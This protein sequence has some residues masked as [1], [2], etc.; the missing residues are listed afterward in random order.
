MSV[1]ASEPVLQ[2]DSDTILGVDRDAFVDV[3]NDDERLT[4]G[5][6]FGDAFVQ[7]Y[8]SFESF[9]AFLEASP[10]TVESV[11]DFADAPRDELDRHVAETT[12]F[13]DWQSM[14]RAASEEHVQRSTGY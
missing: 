1:D 14:V 12:D 7:Q 8:T 13:Q 3:L 5:D 2:G 9:Q 6:L 10:L 11:E 4:V